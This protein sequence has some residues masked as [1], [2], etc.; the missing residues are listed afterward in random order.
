MDHFSGPFRHVHFT[1]CGKRCFAC[2][3]TRSL[4]VQYAAFIDP[5]AGRAAAIQVHG[6][7]AE[8]NVSIRIF[9]VLTGSAGDQS[10]HKLTAAVDD[11]PGFGMDQVRGRDPAIV[12]IHIGT[13]TAQ[14]GG[15]DITVD[16]ETSA[17]S[18]S[19]TGTDINIVRRTASLHEQ[20]AFVEDRR[21]GHPGAGLH[22]TASAGTQYRAQHKGVIRCRQNTGRVD[23][24]TG[25][26]GKLHV[27]G[28]I[29]IPEVQA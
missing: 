14:N 20:T 23:G 4:H 7:A 11:D 9:R 16:I 25:N 13:K 21:A 24:H 5:G 3:R 8:V 10:I 27:T 17:E 19:L 22:S 28:S 1:A 12:H 29:K 15:C 18:C 26:N 2:I 6:T